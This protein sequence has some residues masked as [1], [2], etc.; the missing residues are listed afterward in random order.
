M[1]YGYEIQDDG[2]KAVYVF[3]DESNR[4]EWIAARPASRGVL[5]GNSREVKAALYWDT[6]IAA[7]AKTIS[8]SLVEASER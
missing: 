4:V 7:G 3:G 8:K 2:T 5:S 6:V 1:K